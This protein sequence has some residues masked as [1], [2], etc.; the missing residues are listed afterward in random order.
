MTITLCG[1]TR[2]GKTTLG[3]AMAKRNRWRFLDTDDLLSQ[4]YH[5]TTGND[6]PVRDIYR[7]LGEAGFRKLEHTVV[8]DIEFDGKC[9]V[10][11]GGG[12]AIGVSN[13]NHLKSLGL[14]VYLK[15][16]FEV[17]FER[18]EC[19]PGSP[20]FLQ[21]DA[22]R[23]SFEAHFVAREPIYQKGADIVLDI[24]QQSRKQILRRL[25]EIGERRGQ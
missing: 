23:A 18:L 6:L 1:F 14:L 4:R 12:V 17:L 25:C 3:R 5:D 10:A 8:K 22:S 16:P 21:D 20:A 13:V 11:A 7:E 15:M 19:S 9:V 24:H 2:C